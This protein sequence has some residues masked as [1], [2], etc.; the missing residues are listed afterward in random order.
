M[1]T[2]LKTHVVSENNDNNSNRKYQGVGIESKENKQDR[3]DDNDEKNSKSESQLKSIIEEIFANIVKENN[4]VLFDLVFEIWYKATTKKN[5]DLNAQQS[6]APIPTPLPLSSSNAINILN[7]DNR[8]DLSVQLFDPA[9]E[10]RNEKDLSLWFAV[11]DKWFNF[12]NNF[13]FTKFFL[14][15]RYFESLKFS[16][17][18]K[19]IHIPLDTLFTTYGHNSS[20]Y[21]VDAQK[22]N[23]A[24]MTTISSLVGHRKVEI[25]DKD[26]KIIVDITHRQSRESLAI[27]DRFLDHFTHSKACSSNLVYMNMR[28]LAGSFKH[29]KILTGNVFYVNAVMYTLFTKYNMTFA[30]ETALSPDARSIVTSNYNKIL[31]DLINKHCDVFDIS[32]QDQI[33]KNCKS[34]KRI[35]AAAV[36]EN[37]VYLVQYIVSLLKIDNNDNNDDEKSEGVL[38]SSFIFDQFDEDYRLRV[39]V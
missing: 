25:D 35:I 4:P 20:T 36:S 38:K 29:D 8:V 37:N 39:Q 12:N 33:E 27:I 26:D 3:G 6:G 23:G 32:N 5:E 7:F 14:W 15:D 18:Y 24:P 30:L 13:R 11:F 31:I 2:L 28:Q 21:I 19:L 1:I 10:A 22:A 16:L 9:G 17:K 34:I